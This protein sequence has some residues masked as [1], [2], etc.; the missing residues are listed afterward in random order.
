MGTIGNLNV[1]GSVNTMNNGYIG[2]YN[3][4]GNA[5]MQN[6][7]HVQNA[8]MTDHTQTQNNGSMANVK[9]FGGNGD[10]VNFQNNGSVNNLD[11]EVF[12]PANTGFI[13]IANNG[14]MNNVKMFDNVPVPPPPR[15]GGDLITL[16]NAGHIN[17]VNAGTAGAGQ[18]N[19]FNSGS[20]N[21][22][23]AWGNTNIWNA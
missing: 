12:S 19:I 8:Y 13:N 15:G 9:L 21:N 18:N 17:N 10:V 5:A 3:A 16:N 6:N 4:S 22:L 23:F 2:N 20:I 14:F 11:A 7:G 1:Q